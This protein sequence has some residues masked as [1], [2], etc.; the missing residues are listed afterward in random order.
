MLIYLLL[1]FIVHTYTTSLNN[2]SGTSSIS[3]NQSS[4][5]MPLVRTRSLSISKPLHTELQALIAFGCYDSDSVLKRGKS[6]KKATIIAKLHNLY[7]PSR[8]RC[9]GQISQIELILEGKGKY[10][11]LFE[12]K[13]I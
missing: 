12:D 5:T 6:A 13:H 8:N 2:I 10:K 1:V 7:M 3:I 11:H 9:C 4:I